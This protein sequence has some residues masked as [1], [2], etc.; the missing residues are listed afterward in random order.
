MH[1]ILIVDD[2]PMSL[3]VL[4]RLLR[5]CYRLRAARSGAQALRILGQPPLPDLILL[6]IL[7]PGIGGYEVLQR[8]RSNPAT[9]AI[10]VIILTSLD[11]QED[12][13]R[14]LRLGANDYLTKPLK[15]GILLAR[16]EVQLLASQAREWLRDQNTALDAEVRRRMRENEL[17]ER[18]AIRA[19]AHLAEIRDPETG[20]HI[21][22]TQNY[23]GTLALR[24]VGHPRFEYALKSIN[25]DLL[26]KSAPLH[27]IGKVGIPDQVLLKP[28]PLNAEEW[29]VMKTHA[30][31][32][33][34]AIAR[35]EADVEQ[36]LPFLGCAKTIARWHHERWDGA[37]YPDGLSG[38]AI[39]IAARLMALADVFDALI[40]KRVYKPALP[41]EEARAIIHEGRGSHFDPDVVDAFEKDYERFVCIARR[42]SEAEKVVREPS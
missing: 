19:L 17:V 12:E 33:A 14:G 41:L 2:D 11:A 8:M 36:P 42:F 37:G 32:G 20:N 10:P 23:V 31:L 26:V 21:L 7:M 39:P 35:A 24:L 27:D 22:R 25:V 16:V 13:E 29:A 34:D 1:T 15:P 9:A 6:D 38:E 18:V 4:N 30:Q 40:N 28:G 5:G 3:A